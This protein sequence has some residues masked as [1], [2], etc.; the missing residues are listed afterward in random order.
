MALHEIQNTLHLSELDKRSMYEL[1]TLLFEL[2]YDIDVDGVYGE[3][4]F[5][6][7]ELFKKD[8]E[9]RGIRGYIGATTV[10]KLFEQYDGEDVIENDV[11]KYKIEE[12]R[13][14]MNRK[15][16]NK[17]EWSDWKEPVSRFFT[18]GEV[19][20]GS[21]DRLTTSLMIREKILL[22]ANQLDKI[23][24]D[25]GSGIGVVSWYRPEAI[26]RRAGG[27][28]ASRHCFGDAADIYPI[29]GDV[30][31]FQSWVEERWFGGM[32]LSASKKGF[33]HLDMRN[34]RGWK[35]GGIKG[36]RWD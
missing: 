4:T 19:F 25:W 36:V 13:I 12:R 11:Q 14:P 34:N 9:V 23:R 35:S 17:I 2:G 30:R 28:S 32:G 6:V 1:Q 18:V 21:V 3:N 27:S 29:H 8:Y 7:L 33:V 22:M 26:N 31:R 5:D 20:N 10:G 24:T 15:S 16:E